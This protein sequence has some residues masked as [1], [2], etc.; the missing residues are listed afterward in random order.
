VIT[1]ILEKLGFTQK[2]AEIYLA[3]LQYG[4]MT[5]ADLSKQTGIRRPTV[6][7]VSKELIK[8]GM[9]TEDLG[10]VSRKLLAKPPQDLAI[11]T[12]REERALAQKKALVGQAV[13]ELRAIAQNAQYEVPK[14]VFIPQDQLEA[15]L[16][17]RADTWNESIREADGIWWGFQNHTFVESYHDFLDWYWRESDHRGVEIHLLS[18]ESDIEKTTD[19]RQ[20]KDRQIR[21]WNPGKAFSAT[22]W[23]CGDFLIMI[24]TDTPFYLVE[25]HDRVLAENMRSMFHGLWNL[26]QKA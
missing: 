12:N 21:F 14:I 18:N 25:I 1:A 6:Y 10:G 23:V 26:T 19:L 5:P 11:L 13:Q 8:K 20:Y 7:S 9:V 2:E 17:K 24:T 3:L 15:Y 16:Y 22:L 4:S